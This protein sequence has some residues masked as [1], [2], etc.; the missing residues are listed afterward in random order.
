MA[1]VSEFLPV[2]PRKASAATRRR[3]VMRLAYE[4]HQIVPDAAT[5]LL[6]PVWT[7]MHGS[8]ERVYV[9]TARSA[10]SKQHLRIPAGGS[11]TLAA[12]MQGAYPGADW[13]RP[14]TW[15]ADTN[16]LTT[17]GQASRAFRDSDDAGYV[18]SLDRYD[19]RLAKEAS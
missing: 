7:D 5:V 15:H 2:R 13:D 8:T 14:Q 10:D 16:R 19:A 4:V 17:W 11:R 1:T 12:L 6:T 9:V 18:E 3:R